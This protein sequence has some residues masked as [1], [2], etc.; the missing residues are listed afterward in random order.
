MEMVFSLHLFLSGLGVGFG[1]IIAIGMQNAFVLK[2]AILK[3]H[4]W[5]IAI[6]CSV[7]DAILIIA[8][9]NGL[10]DIL[11]KNMTLL[12]IFHWGGILFL[13]A[14]GIKAFK[15]SFQR[16]S[17]TIDNQPKILSLQQVIITLLSVT[18]L[19]PHTYLDSCVLMASITINL[20]H[21]EKISF[22]I[23]A[24]MASFIWFFLLSFGA[25]FL[26]KFFAKPLSWRILDF[27][28]GCVMFSISIS[29]LCNLK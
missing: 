8:G 14:Y 2:Q 11:S 27:I 6:L 4:V 28:I 18:L 21:N 20:L 17:L 23:G 22:T 24:V 15:S 5:V 7:I 26:R 16:N 12:T 10:G 25:R 13:F 9:I 1:L 19:N 3:N 29:L